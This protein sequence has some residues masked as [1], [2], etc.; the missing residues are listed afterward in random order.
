MCSLQAIALPADFDSWKRLYWQQLEEGFGWQW[1]LLRPFFANK[2]YNLYV[3]RGEQGL[4]PEVENDPANDSFGLLGVRT[5]FRRRPLFWCHVLY[6]PS[7][8]SFRVLIP[9]ILRGLKSGVPV[10]CQLP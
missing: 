6:N 3:Y 10:I 4:K 1:E 8:C 9:S 7:S 5:N 2:G